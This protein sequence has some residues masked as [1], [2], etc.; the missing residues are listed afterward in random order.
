[1]QVIGG[2]DG[3]PLYWYG[4]VEHCDLCRSPF[5]KESGT[6]MYDFKVTAAGMWGNGCENCF[7]REGG[8]V[9]LGFGQKYVR[10][11]DGRF[12]CTEGRS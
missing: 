9:G 1:M 2:T 10:Q 11:S 12:L 4:D 5:S 8:R 7:Q 6:V 3:E